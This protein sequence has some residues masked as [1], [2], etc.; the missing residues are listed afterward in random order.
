MVCKWRHG[1][2]NWSNMIKLLFK[3]SLHQFHQSQ[4][5]KYYPVNIRQNFT[6]YRILPDSGILPDPDTGIRTRYHTKCI[7][8]SWIKD[9]TI[10]LWIIGYSRVLIT[11]TTMM[12]IILWAVVILGNM[13]LS[14]PPI[15]RS[16]KLTIT[17]T[18]PIN[19]IASYTKKKACVEC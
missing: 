15:P 7:L 13:R 9:L 18:I 19:S 2:S 14:D 3:L 17:A 11:S 12:R 5:P 10:L 8:I 4:K 1:S 16:A 6:G